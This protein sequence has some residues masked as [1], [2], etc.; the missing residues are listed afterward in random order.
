[1]QLVSVK[2]RIKHRPTFVSACRSLGLYLDVYLTPTQK[3]INQYFRV[4]VGNVTRRF[5]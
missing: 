2:L 5:L 1:M 4:N 3:Q